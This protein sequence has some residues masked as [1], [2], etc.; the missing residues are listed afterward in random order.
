[1]PVCLAGALLGY[2]VLVG[3][4]AAIQLS[5]RFSTTLVI[6]GWI[7]GAAISVFFALLAFV[8]RLWN[9]SPEPVHRWVVFLIGVLF[10][11]QVVNVIGA[12]MG[13]ALSFL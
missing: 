5:P 9:Q 10:G 2:W 11:F 7:V 6:G 4:L 12:L 1:M 8:I 3:L 13:L